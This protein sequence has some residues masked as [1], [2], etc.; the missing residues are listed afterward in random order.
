MAEVKFF[1]GKTFQQC[2]YDFWDENGYDLAYS[3]IRA[4]KEKTGCSDPT[5]YKYLKR[6]KNEKDP[7][8]EIKHL[9]EIAKKKLDKSQNPAYFKI[10]TDL[11]QQKNKGQVEEYLPEKYIEIGIQLK[12]ELLESLAS[13]GY[14]P[15][16][17]RAKEQ[18][19]KPEDD[20]NC[21]PVPSLPNE[22]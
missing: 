6:Y 19:I 13:T 4:F 5:Y 22:E 12:N 15:V 20:E 16:C 7:D 14:C 18:E 3:D 17:N 10:Y 21:Q 1:E 8:Y 2:L 9:L 11:V